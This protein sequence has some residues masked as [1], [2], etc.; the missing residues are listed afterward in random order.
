M[1]IWS[2]IVTSPFVKITNERNRRRVCNTVNGKMFEAT[3]EIV[4]LLKALKFPICSEALGDA[5]PEYRQTLPG[6]LK[7]MLDEGI[8]MEIGNEDIAL[9]GV[10]PV[11]ERMFGLPNYNPK[12]PG[13]KVPFVG[14]PFGRGNPRS[15]A[16]GN[17]PWELREI[18]QKLHLNFHADSADALRF[19]SINGHLDF[20]RL[21][22]LIKEEALTD[23][24]NIFMDMNESSNFIYDK[25]YAVAKKL[26]NTHTIPFFIG[27]DHSISYPLIR[28]ASEQY[29]NLHVIHFDAHTDTY[30]LPSDSL[31]HSGKTHH[32]GNFMHE[33]LKN[34]TVAKVYQLGIRGASN[35]KQ[36][37]LPRQHI[38]WC[39]HLKTL[40]AEGG[41]F[42]LP[43]DV[44]YYI[45]FDID[46]VDPAYAPGT[47]TPVPGGFTPYEIQKL[48]ALT[49]SD[50]HIVG[51]DFVEASGEHDKSNITTEYAI[52]LILSLL[53]FVDKERHLSKP[54]GIPEVAVF[55]E[56]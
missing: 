8:I 44:P 37:E 13:I 21:K 25:I 43:N 6:I 20:D 9:T 35:L 38:H 18:T 2:K 28:A 10:T 52:E 47:A 48:L 16:T 26:F 12:S 31:V 30:I 51:F 33:C 55:Q 46:V 23:C 5:F 27:G 32:H 1:K 56:N 19:E 41:K 22:T 49:L 11:Y 53:S 14:I 54:L 36:D 4:T 50:K 29:N 40:I 34:T 3:P 7:R 15:I 39:S 24:G 42:C 45:T 17:F